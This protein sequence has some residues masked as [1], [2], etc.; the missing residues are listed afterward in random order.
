MICKYLH[1]CVCKV[2]GVYVLVAYVC[3]DRVM[4]EAPNVSNLEHKE[5]LS[6][7]YEYI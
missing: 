1:M 3:G 5:I 7:N 2:W 4:N 6:N